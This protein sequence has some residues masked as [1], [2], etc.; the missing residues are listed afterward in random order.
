VTTPPI[1]V[2]VPGLG[3][4]H[5]PGVEL[6]GSDAPSI[7]GV[8]DAPPLPGTSGGSSSSSGSTGGVG[9]PPPAG[10]TPPQPADPAAPQTGATA[11]PSSTPRDPASS[12]EGGRALDAASRRRATDPSLGSAIA[13]AVTEPSTL[14]GALTLALGFG[15]VVGAAPY[16]PRYRRR[17]RELLD[18]WARASEREHAVAATLAQADQQKSEFLALVS[19]ELRT[20]LTAVKG[21]VD[22]V[23]LHWERLPDERRRELLTRASSNADELGRLVRQ[24]MEFGRTES[25]PIEIAPDTLEVAA[26]VDVALCGIAP[27]TA[28]HRVHVDVPSGLAVDADADAFNHVLVNLLTNAVKF[29]PSGST[30]AVCARRDGDEVVVS[31]ADDGAGIALDEQERIFDRF[32][33]SQNGNHAR[34]TGIGLTIA[35]RFTAQHGGRIWVESEPG[36]GATFSFTMPVA[37]GGFVPAQEPE[38]A[39]L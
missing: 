25:G 5:V 24:L 2:G 18:Q 39:I 20:P 11:P 10:P 26:A 21:F 13:G 4:V 34:G 37:D 7:P 27:V 30:V 12:Q 22:T 38:P 3:E 17:Q 36:H 15:V 32:Y 28:D 9:S 8:P 23:L 1:D 29:S 16:L 6:G 35:Q 31:V 14:V 33:Q 19:H